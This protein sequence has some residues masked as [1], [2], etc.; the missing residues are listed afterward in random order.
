MMK[1]QAVQTR[2]VADDA[3]TR[4]AIGGGTEGPPAGEITYQGTITLAGG[5]GAVAVPFSAGASP[6]PYFSLKAVNGSTALGIPIGVIT[7]GMGH[8]I[9]TVTSYEVTS[10]TTQQAGDDSTYNFIMVQS[11]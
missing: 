2:A 9:F 10:P 11:S 1:N 4:G 6:V 5:T 8:Y 3:L 7:A